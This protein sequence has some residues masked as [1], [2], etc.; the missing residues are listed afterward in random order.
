MLER[1]QT[2][3]FWAKFLFFLNIVA[4]I[5]LISLILVFHRAQPEFESFFDR[6]YKLD[7]RTTWDKTYLHY[8]IYTIITGMIISLSGLVLCMYRGRRQNDHQK[9]LIITGVL[10]LIMLVISIFVL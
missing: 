10:S 7:L 9:V 4:W 5:V 2:K 6:F 3:D 1:R 8:L